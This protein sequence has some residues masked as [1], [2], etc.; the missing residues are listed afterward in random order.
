MGLG[1]FDRVN[2]E[3]AGFIDGKRSVSGVCEV[4]EAAVG[5]RTSGSVCAADLREYG[6]CLEAQVDRCE[7]RAILSGERAKMQVFEMRSMVSDAANHRANTRAS[8]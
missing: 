3:I 6:W 8:S 2:A 4:P 1:I 7:A 5:T